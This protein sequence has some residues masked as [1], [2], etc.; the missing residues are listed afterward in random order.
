[1]VRLFEND[2][3]SVPPCAPDYQLID[4]D[5]DFASEFN[6]FSKPRENAKF[7]SARPQPAIHE[8]P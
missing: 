1:M 8:I 4:C 7:E 6:L 5:P 2:R 3:Q